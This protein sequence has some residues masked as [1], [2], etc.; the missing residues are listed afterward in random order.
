MR[1]L[2]A[3]AFLFRQS[4]MA[5]ARTAA[6]AGKLRQSVQLHPSHMTLAEKHSQYS[7]RH[8]DFLQLQRLRGVLMGVMPFGFSLPGTA[9]GVFTI[10]DGKRDGRDVLLDGGGGP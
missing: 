4:V 3:C 7:L 5:F 2:N 8:C 10:E 9:N 6:N 1:G